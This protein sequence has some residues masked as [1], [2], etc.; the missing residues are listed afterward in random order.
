MLLFY[1]SLNFHIL[2]VRLSAKI[3]FKL[4]RIWNVFILGLSVSALCMFVCA[5]VHLE[6]SVGKCF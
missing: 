2:S 3:L 5:C 4:L 1:P 6:G